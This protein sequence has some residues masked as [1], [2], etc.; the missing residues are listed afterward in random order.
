MYTTE[1]AVIEDFLAQ[2]RIALIGVS[3]KP[4][5]FSRSLWAEFRKHGYDMVPVHPEAEEIDGIS[6]VR[7]LTEI[8]PA[9]DAALILLPAAS[10]EQVVRECGEAGIHR[11]WLYRAAGQGA[12]SEA[13]LDFCRDQELSVVA[14][15][16]PFMFL[17][18]A[19]AIHSIHGWWRRL[20][21]NYPE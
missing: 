15:E 17:P 9:A 18:G 11:I 14:G 5:D 10:A 3:R 4:T 21:G 12:V 19:G 1:R 8:R 2:K 16:C 6:C 20:T 13:A 7:R